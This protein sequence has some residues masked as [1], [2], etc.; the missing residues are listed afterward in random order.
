VHLAVHLVMS[1]MMVCW[2]F[3]VISGD[4]AYYY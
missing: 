1:V 4:D 3:R 2:W